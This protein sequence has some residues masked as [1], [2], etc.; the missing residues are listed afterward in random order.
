[1]LDL[2]AHRP[3]HI[4]QVHRR[5]PFISQVFVHGD[6]LRSHIVAI[7]VPDAATLTEWAKSQ[8]LVCHVPFRCTLCCSPTLVCIVPFLLPLFFTRSL[9]YWPL[10]FAFTF[11][12]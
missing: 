10:R 11:C 8:N 5:S 3:E 12:F 1:M 2:D 7:V 9:I 6:S 4:E